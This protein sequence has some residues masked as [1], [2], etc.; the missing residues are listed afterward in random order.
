MTYL[1]CVF[2]YNGSSFGGWTAPLIKQYNG[3][4][5]VC[6]AGADINFY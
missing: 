3:T 1:I 6:N 4:S 2:R 5:D